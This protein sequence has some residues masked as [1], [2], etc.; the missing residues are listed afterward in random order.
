MSS[1]ERLVEKKTS[2]RREN[3]P[4]VPNRF[5]TLRRVLERSSTI[6]PGGVVVARTAFTRIREEFQPTCETGDK[7]R[8]LHSLMSRSMP[9]AAASGSSCRRHCIRQ[10]VFDR[11]VNKFDAEVMPDTAVLL[12]TT[13]LLRLF[14]DNSY[15]I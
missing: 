9:T 6:G 3:C 15:I 8:D 12:E 7:R 4:I 11:A 13:L 2:S 14:D 10:L 1:P 5:S